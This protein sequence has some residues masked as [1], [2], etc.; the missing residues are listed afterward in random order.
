LFSENSRTVP[1]VNYLENPS[2]ESPDPTKNVP[3]FQ[4]KC[5]ALVTDRTK[6]TSAEPIDSAL[7]YVQLQENTLDEKRNKLEKE[8]WSPRTQPLIID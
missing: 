3:V 4:V 8:F 7:P 5:D 1:E 2:N 6:R